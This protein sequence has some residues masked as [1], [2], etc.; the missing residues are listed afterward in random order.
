MDKDRIEDIA[1][2]LKSNVKERKEAADT[3]TEAESMYDRSEEKLG[4]VISEDKEDK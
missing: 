1:A 3:R 2:Q 4:S